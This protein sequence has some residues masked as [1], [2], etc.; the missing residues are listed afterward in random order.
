MT[1][2]PGDGRWHYSDGSTLEQET[3]GSA[4]LL[5]SGRGDDERRGSRRHLICRDNLV[6]RQGVFQLPTREGLSQKKTREGLPKQKQ[7]IAGDHEHERRG[8]SANSSMLF[9]DHVQILTTRFI[10]DDLD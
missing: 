5:A 6:A 10:P 9:R 1:A 3:R 8:G 2:S 7:K 4:R